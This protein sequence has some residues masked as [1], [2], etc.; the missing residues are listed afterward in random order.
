MTPAQLQSAITEDTLIGQIVEEHPEVIET[1]LSY[2]VHCIG[3]HVSPYEPLGDGFRS[4]GLS[5]DEIQGAIRKLNEVALKSSSLSTSNNGSFSSTAAPVHAAFHITDKAAA[6]IKETCQSNHKSALRISVKP[7]GC[8]GF[9]YAMELDDQPDEQDVV[10][11]EKGVSVYIDQASMAKLNGAT[12]DYVE[13]LQAS[14]FKI[15][16]PEASHSCG[17]GKS[18]G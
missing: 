3:C 8:S 15:S 11:V 7:G 5:E 2:G 16:N 17:C 10:I 9:S 12:V 14:G 18:F 6:K 4:H 1:L 13:S